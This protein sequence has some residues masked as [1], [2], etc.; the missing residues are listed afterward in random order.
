MTMSPPLTTRRTPEL[1]AHCPPE[2]PPPPDVLSDVLRAIRLT[3]AV[4][5]SVDAT[6]SFAFEGPLS[7]AVATF[8]HSGNEQV[9]P[10]HA[11]ASGSCWVRVP[12]ERPVQ[13]HAGD[14]VMLP[15]NDRHTVSSEPGLSAGPVEVQL[16]PHSR[17]P[18]PLPVRLGASSGA[19]V[20][21]ICGFL[22]CEV[23]P[24]NPLLTALPRRMLVAR[25]A[26]RG[27]GLGRYIE[28]TRE[29]LRRSGAGREAVLA[30]LAELMFVE[31]MR[32]LVEAAPG[33]M[34]WLAGM[35]D[36]LVGRSL[37]ELHARPGRPWTLDGLA[38]EVGASR[39][40]LAERFTALLG[41]APMQ[42]LARWR[43]QLASELLALTGASIAEIADRLGYGSEAALSRAFKRI[44]GVSPAPW[45]QGRRSAR[46]SLVPD[47]GASPEPMPEILRATGT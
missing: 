27:G 41:M 31:A 24:F 11:I 15:R 22:G 45:R 39:T 12:G 38:R 19:Q 40:V 37:S 18:L 6:G 35:S 44:V 33:E 42:Y 1:A 13:L 43:M 21:V 23:G 47:G 29:E 17:T 7:S 46:G 30:R 34:G 2:N 8:V 3:G 26:A 14:V 25:G 4:F 32:W 28:L 36:E 20:E 5:F 10:F 16:D 9:I